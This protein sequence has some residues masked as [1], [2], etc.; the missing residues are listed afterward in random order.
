M[1]FAASFLGYLF[2]CL[3]FKKIIISMDLS[4]SF[5]E[6]RSSQHILQIYDAERTLAKGCQKFSICSSIGLVKSKRIFRILA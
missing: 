6:R 3:Y 5:F 2:F 1:H 4:I